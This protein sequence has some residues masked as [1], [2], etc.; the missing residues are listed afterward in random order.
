VNAAGG[1]AYSNVVNA[2]TSAGT[3]PIVKNMR[4]GENGYAGN[5]DSY[6]ADGKASTNYGTATTL[7][8]DGADGTNGRLM[9]VLRWDVS[10]I[11]S[12]ASVDSVVLTLQV[13]NLSAGTYKLFP[14]NA[15]WSETSVTYSSLNPLNNIGAEIGSFLPNATGAKQITLN[16]AGM[17]LVKGW[18]NGSVA[19]N[20]FIIIDASTDG[21][22]I[23]S[24]EYGT[25]SQRP[26][27]SVTYQ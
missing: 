17:A 15:G 22:D 23:R 24:S 20:G 14:L 8:A 3:A 27:L 6:I 13:S 5:I 21:L 9:S 7:L 11:P 25:V 19:N 12:T 2:T 16:A 1:S 10:D 18:I 26:M 4:Q